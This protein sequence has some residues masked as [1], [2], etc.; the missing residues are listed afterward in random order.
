MRK[1]I[2]LNHALFAK[3]GEPQSRVALPHTWNNLDGQDGGNDYWRG[4]GIYEIQLPSPTAGKRQYIQF[5]GVNH[6][7]S[8]S[9]NGTQLG[10][11]RGGFSTFRFELTALMQQE[12]NILTV[13]VTNEEC[14]VYPQ[15]ADF[16][17]FGGI[18]R[19][20]TFIET[21]PAHFDLLRSGTQ[22]V[23]VTP[24]VTGTTR[25]DAFPVDAKGCTVSAELLNADG[26]VVA[27]AEVPAEGHTAMILELTEPHLWNGVADP[28][29]YTARLTLKKDGEICDTVSV[30]YGYRSFHVDPEKGFFLNGKS[31]PLHGVS[32]H[33]D[34]LDK[35]WAISRDDHREDM[36]L[37]K[38]VGANT[39]RL[40]HYQ[41]DQFFYDLCDEAGMVVWAEIPFISLFRPSED[42]RQNTLDQMKELIAQNYNHCAICFWGISNEITIGGESEAL[43][44]NLGQL[45]AL[46]K[47]MDP[48][49]LTTMAQ[50][51]MVPMNSEHVYITDV[52]SYNHY[53]GWYGGEIRDNAQ[54]LDEF[55]RK[56]PDRALGIS[57]YGAEAILTWHSEK[58]E[59]HDYTE[60]Y[61]AHYHHEMLKIFA[62]RPYLWSTHVWNMFDFA[63]DARDEGGCKG[64][65]NKG[66][67]TYDRK[68]KK[69]SFFLYKAYWTEAPMVHICGSRFTDRAPGQRNVT[70]YT[71]CPAVTLYL[72][73]RRVG[74]CRAVDHECVFKNVR[75]APGDNILTAKAAGAQNDQILLRGV[76]EPNPDYVLPDGRGNAGNW[77]DSD[78]VEHKMEFPEGCC[79]IRDKLGELLD[80]PEA[81]PMLREMIASMADQVGMGKSI[82]GML[83]MLRSMRLEEIIRMA[84][85]KLPDEMAFK[86]NE[87][88]I[89]FKK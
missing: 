34:R 64:R 15:H 49:R 72:N 26:G 29:L 82:N 88:L 63:A 75:L 66:L 65:N 4:H 52:Q 57:E 59:N 11:H 23:F 79:S 44:R 5:E 84:G 85:N 51:S 78:G 19:N 45:N 89:Q 67:V 36:E 18:Y 56:N 42:A 68:T 60:E 9:C 47:A 8:V 6:I 54:W 39:I 20:V 13:D 58:P 17:F 74:K 22:G 62:T 73:N 33:Q 24:H 32:R 12:N 37:I 77:F 53:F 81:G 16:T 61:Q 28:Y 41:H 27:S 14:D 35:G 83:R 38:E 71:N 87:K 43:Y 7:A 21:E 30:R 69:D 70:V 55:H 40:A 31:C 10:G 48:S 25:I 86:L 76:K 2:I 46:A 3:S 1:E 80:H 50:V